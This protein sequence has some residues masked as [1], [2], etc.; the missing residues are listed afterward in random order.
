[1]IPS[2]E[3]RISIYQND[4]YS[5]LLNLGL[6]G[7]FSDL[8][9]QYSPDFV[10]KVLQEYLSVTPHTHSRIEDVFWSFPE[11]CKKNFS[12]EAPALYDQSQCIL[13]LHHYM[14]FHKDPELKTTLSY[15]NFSN[16]YLKKGVFYHKPIS[17][18][19]DLFGLVLRKKRA[20]KMTAL[21][22][23]KSTPN[24]PI[25]LEVEVVFQ[26]LIE[27]LLN[28]KNF[29]ESS[30]YLGEIDEIQF[31]SFCSGLSSFLTNYE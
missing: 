15:E 1:M 6:E 10:I 12:D 24:F 5:R 26:P 9:I 3:S 19:A 21:A 16:L 23:H 25:Y 14:H 2:H 11:F 7:L 22:C 8:S 17:K 13:K 27:N 31:A 20:K 29:L 18:D 4:Y 28:E 30:S